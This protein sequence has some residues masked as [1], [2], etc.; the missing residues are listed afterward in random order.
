MFIRSTKVRS[1]SGVVHEYVRI[2]ES[3]WEQGRV[4]QNVVA[5]LGRR[6]VLESVLP[7]L[8]RFLSG[9]ADPA[10][11][12]LQQ[13]ASSD[14]IEALDASTWGPMLVVRHLF[15]KLDLWKLLRRRSPLAEADARGRSQRRLAQ[16]RIGIAG[17]SAHAPQQRACIGE[18]AG[19]R[20]RL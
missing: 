16:S 1:S 15:E 8:N 3:V 6:D 14:A 9:E 20:L 17:E 18:L 4:K 2:V 5:N 19:D 7:M 12:L 13:P 10:T 11:K